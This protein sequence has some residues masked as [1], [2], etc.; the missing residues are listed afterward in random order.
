M[1]KNTIVM[2]SRFELE[3]AI[4]DA[5]SLAIEKYS[6]SLMKSNGSKDNPMTTEEAAEFLNIKVSTLYTKISKREI[7]ACKKG[8]RLYF[9]RADLV[10][11]VSKGRRASEDEIMGNIEDYMIQ[12]KKR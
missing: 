12:P 4:N 7:A 5:A 9:L 11:Y 6:E 2:I 8:K 3:T 1:D 10:D